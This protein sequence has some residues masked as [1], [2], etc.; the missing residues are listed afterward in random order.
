MSFTPDEI[1]KIAH[2]ARLSISDDELEKY[3]TQLSN[4]L[5][6]TAA[7]DKIDTSGIEPLSHAVNVTQPLRED[8]VTEPNLR[9]KFQAIA[10]ET[11]A[12][13]YLVP[14]VIE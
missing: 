13:L 7:M 1:K 3:T 2:L 11:E 14:V 9:E 5:D 4:I 6:F 10:P 12:G 8:I